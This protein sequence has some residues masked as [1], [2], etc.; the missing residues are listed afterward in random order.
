ME[1]ID[2]TLRRVFSG[3]DH[4]DQPLGELLLP[5]V[6]EDYKPPMVITT[7]GFYTATATVSNN[8]IPNPILSV[9]NNVDPIM[10]SQV[11]LQGW[12]NNNTTQV[13]TANNTGWVNQTA[14]T[15]NTWGDNNLVVNGT[16]TPASGT[17]NMYTYNSGWILDTAEEEDDRIRLIEDILGKD[18]EDTIRDGA[19]MAIKFL[20]DSE[21]KGEERMYHLCAQCGAVI[22]DDDSSIRYYE[23]CEDCAAD[24]V[25]EYQDPLI[26]LGGDNHPDVRFI[27]PRWD[28]D[29][30]REFLRPAA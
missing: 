1:D 9:Q 4:N 8:N 23:I 14:A 21:E 11:F 20:H 22:F 30:R 26:L 27:I 29:W 5:F 3:R 2:L 10:P 13:I 18:S 7:G 24:K 28:D 15:A 17:T 6:D 19:L 12:A 16:I 25:A